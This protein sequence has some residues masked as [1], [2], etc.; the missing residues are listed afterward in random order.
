MHLPLGTSIC[1]LGRVLY[2]CVDEVRLDMATTSATATDTAPRSGAAADRAVQK[3]CFIARE[4]FGF[5]LF[6][7]FLDHRDRAVDD[8][9]QLRVDTDSDAL[10]GLGAGPHIPLYECILC[11]LCWIFTVLCLGSRPGEG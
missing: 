2:H 7:V 5:G 8:W 9:Q 10:G 4:N 1:F 3:S 6:S 11:G